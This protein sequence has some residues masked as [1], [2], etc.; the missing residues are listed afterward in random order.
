VHIGLTDLPSRLPTQ[1]KKA[2]WLNTELF[3]IFESFIFKLSETLALAS[4][5]DEHLPLVGFYMS[6][7]Q[8]TWLNFMA[9][10]LA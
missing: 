3:F 7:I 6:N 1:V 10:K 9:K 4:T 8:V 5:N 2:V